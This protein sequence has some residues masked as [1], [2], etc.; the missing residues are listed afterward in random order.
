M[1]ATLVRR[2]AALSPWTLLLA[3]AAL[4]V[5]N[6]PW[7]DALRCR[8][9]DA[10]QR[11]HPRPY[12]EVPVRVLDIDDATLARIGQW[13]WPRTLL[14]EVVQ[15]LQTLGASAIAFDVLFAEPDRTSPAQV[16]PLW[17]TLPQA[18]RLEALTAALPDHDALFAAALKQAPTVLGL[19]LTDA[20]RGP[21]APAAKAGW[22]FAGPLPQEAV[23]VLSGA[24][25][26]LPQLAEAAAGLGHVNPFPDVDGVVRRVPLLARHEEQFYPA[27][28]L[29]A[30][31]VASGTTAYL[32][33]ATGASGERSFGAPPGVV[34]L[35]VGPH[36]IPT[37][38][39]GSL[40]VYYTRE[41]P[42]RTIP[43][44]Q[45]LAGT[46][47]ADALK[48]AVVL[49]GTSAAGLKDLRATP[50]NP[51]AAGVDIHAQ[52]LEQML[53]QTFLRRPDWAR[54]AEL[55]YLLLLGAVLLLWL[56][57]VGALWCAVLGGLAMG[58]ACWSSWLAFV[59]ARWL[60]DPVL[61][62]LVALLMYAVMSLRGYLRAEAQQRQIRHAFSR[63]MSPAM[64]ERLARHPELLRLGGEMREMTLLFAD[65]RDFTTIAE[66]LD[67][68]ALT[69]FLNR[70]LT[71]MTRFILAQEGTIDKYIGDCVMAFWNAPLDQPRHA[72]QA[73]TAALAMRAYLVDWNRQQREATVAA[74]GTPPRAVHIGIGINTGACCV[75]NMGS[76]Q[77]FSYS[78][79]GDPVNL[80]ARF[81]S[82][83]KLYGTDIVVGESTAAHAPDVA[84][85]E[86]DLV[87]VKGKARPVRLYALLGE[88]ALRQAHAG[89]W[90]AQAALLAAYR[91]GDWARAGAQVDACLTLDTPHTRLRAYYALMRTRIAAYQQHPPAPEWE[92]V[93]VAAE[94]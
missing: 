50:L 36:R 70:F 69:Q 66:Q 44:W 58:L 4:Q 31:R 55:V 84:L 7:V 65:L 79:L 5:S 61:P 54:G 78:V 74:G 11:A 56:P 20:Q 28:A 35:K 42:A 67:A 37:D 71:P 17:A 87:A 45:L 92:G 73:C 77:R 24:V 1:R 91:A 3:A 94:K 26:P 88:A 83:S 60:L 64:V 23:P 14:A 41:A 6:P 81:E 93:F 89:L 38:A 72:A 2:V 76:E 43:A 22:A 19:A 13:P 90:L 39:D 86:L 10:F 63:Y 80:A 59:H 46:L 15:R 27:L 75:G 47:P 30:L 16:L 48:D 40:W 29:E 57:R 53:T 34:E 21:P 18:S 85:L 9:F 52:A 51:T 25:W 8:V 49:V 33:K 68:Q 32:V 82:L 62:S 12:V